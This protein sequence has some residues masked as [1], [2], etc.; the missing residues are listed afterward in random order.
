MNLEE[1]EIIIQ[2]GESE[3]LEFKKSTSLLQ[4]TA[5]TLCAFLNGKGGRVLIGVSSDKALGQHVSDN[6]LQEIAKTLSKFEP[7]PI[8]DFEQVSILMI[9][10]KFGMMENFLLV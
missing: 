4:A 7:Q 2:N 8:I 6:T 1:L 9:D 5:E 3:I 10:W